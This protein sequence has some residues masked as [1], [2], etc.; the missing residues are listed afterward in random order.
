MTPE[1]ITELVRIVKGA[2]SKRVA[3]DIVRRVAEL[4]AEPGQRKLVLEIVYKYGKKRRL[5]LSKRQ[6]HS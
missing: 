4:S 1:T 5:A 3:L 2:H 6:G